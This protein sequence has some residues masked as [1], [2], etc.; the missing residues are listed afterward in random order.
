MLAVSLGTCK[1]SVCQLTTTNL[2][3][4]GEP[5]VVRTF[6]EDN[7]FRRFA[8]STKTLSNHLETNNFDSKTKGIISYYLKLN[9]V[10]EQEDQPALY[11]Q[12][13]AALHKRTNVPNQ[14][15]VILPEDEKKFQ[16]PAFYNISDHGKNT[17][18]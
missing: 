10:D 18:E 1:C 4:V 17:I 16:Q 5:N 13:L 8:Q 9:G 14:L 11:A 3:Q 6:Q 15:E 2:R 7:N 12:L